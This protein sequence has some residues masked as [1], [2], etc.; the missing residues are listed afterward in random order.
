MRHISPFPVTTV[1]VIFNPPFSNYTKFVL[2]QGKWN[3]L[4]WGLES[5]LPCVSVTI[6]NISIH[7]VILS[8]KLTRLW[9]PRACA[10]GGG[11]CLKWNVLL[12]F[13]LLHLPRSLNHCLSSP[14][15][16]WTV[17]WSSSFFAQSQTDE[18]PSNRNEK[19][20]SVFE[21]KIHNSSTSHPPWPWP[22]LQG[23]LVCI[24]IEILGTS[25]LVTCFRPCGIRQ[26]TLV[27]LIDSLHWLKFKSHSP[28]I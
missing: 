2:T 23:P 28:F 1:A 21:P 16:N 11:L 24:D 27:L 4:D 14:V 18:I 7:G 13:S 22:H 20:L 25:G 5:P 19:V 3:M 12:A 26:T 9:V 8:H 17:G 10:G 6:F 15:D